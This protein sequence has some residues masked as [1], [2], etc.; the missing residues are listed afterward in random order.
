VALKTSRSRIKLTES[1]FTRAIDTKVRHLIEG[2]LEPGERALAAVSGGQDSTAMLMILSRLATHFGLELSAATF[3]HQLRAAEETAGDRVFVADVCA[4]AGVPLSASSG[5]VADRAR[6]RKETVEE[7]A[8]NL[9]YVF[10][11]EE[12]RR[13]GADLVAVGHTR[14]DRAETVLMH[15]IRGSGLEGL[16][17]MNVLDSWPFGTGPDVFRPLLDLTREE[18]RRYCQESG[19]EP[20][21]D[22]TNELL[23]AT[24]N[25][26]RHEVMPLLRSINPRVDEALSR[27]AD[28]A[29]ADSAYLDQATREVWAAVAREDRSD[30]EFDRLSLLRLHPA[31]PPRL[32]RMAALRLGGPVPAHERVDQAMSA[33]AKGR[34]KIEFPGGI[35]LVA[36]RDKLKVSRGSSQDA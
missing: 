25:R 16:A 4:A 30:I 7:A 23:I 24:R 34:G 5:D 9:R 13:V 3:D 11:A 14:D 32:L 36:S 26:V 12:A 8:R 15:I 35:L 1:P 17:V 20:R 2:V 6:T 28:S 22:P 18:T 21:D 29:A 33:L 10:L 27:L 19:I 31:M